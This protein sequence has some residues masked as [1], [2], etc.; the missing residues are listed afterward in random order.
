MRLLH[1][2]EGSLPVW[3]VDPLPATGS[4][5]VEMYTTIAAM[6]GGRSAGRS[7]MHSHAELNAALA[8]IGSPQVA[9]SGPIDD[10]SADA[11][12]T[13]AWMRAHADRADLWQPQGLTAQIAQ[14]EGW[15]FGVP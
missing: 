3:P 15:T 14:T 2:L 9:G 10:H 1:R 12:A 8:E 7:K 11:L 5:L 13:A 4:V 6:A